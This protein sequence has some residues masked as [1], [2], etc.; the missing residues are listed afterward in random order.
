MRP[1]FVTP[2]LN[3]YLFPMSLTTSSTMLGFP[4]TLFTTSC[5][6]PEDFVKTRTALLL[7]PSKRFE[8]V[9]PAPVNDAARRNSRRLDN[10]FMP[11]LLVMSLRMFATSKTC[12][13]AVRRPS[14]LFHSHFRRIIRSSPNPSSFQSA[15]GTRQAFRPH[16][17][18]LSSLSQELPMHPSA[19]GF[20]GSHPGLGSTS[21]IAFSTP[22]QTRQASPRNSSGAQAYPR[23]AASQ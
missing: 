15:G 1:S 19:V 11:S 13:H 14:Q 8:S 4:P 20:S 6:Q 7:A 17:H 5:S 2:T 16:L 21:R 3:P 9:S 10:A 12:K 18:R 22:L 23:S